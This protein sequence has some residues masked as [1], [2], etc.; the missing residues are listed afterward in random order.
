MIAQGPSIND[1]THFLRFFFTSLPLSP[2][3]L[4]KQ[5]YGVTSTFSRSPFAPK[6]VMSF[7]DNRYPLSYLMFMLVGLE[8]FLSVFEGLLSSPRGAIITGRKSRTLKIVLVP[9]LLRQ[10]VPVLE[11]SNV[12]QSDGKIGFK[13]LFQ[14]VRDTQ[15]FYSG[16]LNFTLN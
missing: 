13:I 16:F 3:L 2:I 1:V 14:Q 12:I 7:M 6:W 9:Y 10:N 15:T 4:L 5:A 8:L 11:K